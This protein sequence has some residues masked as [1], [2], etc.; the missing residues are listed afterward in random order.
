MCEMVMKNGDCDGS[1]FSCVKV[2]EILT[3]MLVITYQS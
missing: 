1:K 3:S 2:S